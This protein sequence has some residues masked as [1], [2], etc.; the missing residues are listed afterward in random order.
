[1]VTCS[2]YVPLYIK[3]HAAVVAEVPN[4]DKAE[5][6]VACS[7]DWVPEFR[8]TEQPFGGMVRDARFTSASGAA[9]VRKAKLVTKRARMFDSCI[10]LVMFRITADDTPV[11][12]NRG[13]ASV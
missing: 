2:L 11:V 1:M 6:K 5:P 3:I 7:P 13:H 4:A 9:A 10:L 12:V 8:T